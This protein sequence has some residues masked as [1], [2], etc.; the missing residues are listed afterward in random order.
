MA[1]NPIS[2]SKPPKMLQINIPA[3]QNAGQ[4]HNLG[5][6]QALRAA[7]AAAAALPLGGGNPG[8][9]APAS[10][11]SPNTPTEIVA[12]NL[13]SASYILK[14][15]NRVQNPL[16]KNIL[17]TWIDLYSLLTDRSYLG[18][19]HRTLDLAFGPAHSFCTAKVEISENTTIQGCDHVQKSLHI[20]SELTHLC[21]EIVEEL[22]TLFFPAYRY[23]IA[24]NNFDPQL[25]SF[26]GMKK[27]GAAI[28]RLILGGRINDIDQ[29]L[30][31]CC[32]MAETEKLDGFSV[33]DK[34]E[35]SRYD[36]FLFLKE[37][38]VH[39]ASFHFRVFKGM[40]CE[41]LLSLFETEPYK[42]FVLVEN[43]PAL[44]KELLKEAYKLNLIQGINNESP[45]TTIQ[46]WMQGHLREK[47][48]FVFGTMFKCFKNDLGFQRP[49]ISGAKL[50][51]QMAL[52]KEQF[53]YKTHFADEEQIKSVLQLNILYAFEVIESLSE[54]IFEASYEKVQE[55]AFE[56]TLKTEFHSFAVRL[57][58]LQYIAFYD[59]KI[60][61]AIQAIDDLQ[62]RLCDLEKSFHFALSKEL[63]KR[64]IPFE[65]G[66]A[67]SFNQDFYKQEKSRVVEE[68]E[69]ELALK[70]ALVSKLFKNCYA[71]IGKLS[72]YFKKIGFITNDDFSYQMAKSQST[73][74][75]GNFA[76]SSDALFLYPSHFKDG[77][78]IGW[79]PKTR[80]G[81]PTAACKGKQKEKE[82]GDCGKENEE[83]PHKPQEPNML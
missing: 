74:E 24:S 33:L 19:K 71:H 61:V 56:Q 23:G 36:H 48:R 70:E 80:N 58:Q 46:R 59:K 3:A 72:G 50:A 26:W 79:V 63:D 7:A 31:H 16:R 54:N 20:K 35:D 39:F 53:G 42:F 5:L 22:S 13:P 65:S 67:R 38:L 62:Q 49:P 8:P 43:R 64:L 21:K 28:E 81:K 1:T 76:C 4:P 18:A 6:G 44:M 69:K 41:P 45:Q 73:Y 68:W 78:P 57:N 11:K 14:V 66:K 29:I 25:K 51:E 32:E 10:P 77:C 9:N 82:E 55:A 27:F 47:R 30:E 83:K 40:I 75:K 34:Q 52:C 12:H 2:L 60:S 37:L 15:I 17:R